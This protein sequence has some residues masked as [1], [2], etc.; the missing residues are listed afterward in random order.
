M[1][2][3]QILASHIV[4]ETN[5]VES[6]LIVQPFIFPRMHRSMKAMVAR[7]SRSFEAFR[8]GTR[9]KQIMA[10]AAICYTCNPSSLVMRESLCEHLGIITRFESPRPSE[11]ASVP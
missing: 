6:T 4:S 2:V 8:G 1:S 9:M 3:P 11:A 10:S 7:L 5:G